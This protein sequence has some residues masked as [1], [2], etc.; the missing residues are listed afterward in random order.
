MRVVVLGGYGNFGARICR[1][2]AGDAGIELVIAGR[3]EARAVAFATTLAKSVHAV[4]LDA[5]ALD[6]TQRLSV[7]KP[8]LVIHTAGPFQGQGYDA[9]RAIAECGA[10]YIDLADG[11]RFVCDFSDALDAPFKAAGRTAFSGVSTLPTLSAAVVDDLRDR[12]A[13]LSSIEICIAPGQQ[14]PRGKATLAAVLSYCGETIQ[15]WQGGRWMPH[16]GWSNPTRI[17]FAQ[18]P[19]R[20]GAVCDV[21]DLELFPQRYPGVNNVM[22]RAALEVELTQRVFALIAWARRRRLLPRASLLAPL[23]HHTGTWLDRF[24]SGLGGMVIRL[25]GLSLQ[26]Q[27]LHLE[28]HLTVDNNYGP[29]VPC[30]AAI[31]LAQRLAR[32][33]TFPPG[34]QTSPGSLLLHEFEPEFAR[35]GIQTEVI[36]GVG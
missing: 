16:I 35:W 23:L 17:L 21:P 25:D 5:G 1:G 28:W 7:L 2:L 26:R 30:M 34:A 33:D 29:E 14:A 9:A 6:F 18:L 19:S 20:R 22:F 15:V 11:R 24:G 10:H 13:E 4:S 32:G 3:N 36:E 31:L 12:F 27:P 8:D